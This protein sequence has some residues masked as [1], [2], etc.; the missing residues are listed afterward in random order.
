MKN[1]LL[2]S[3]RAVHDR[4]T[5]TALF[6]TFLKAKGYRLPTSAKPAFR[7]LHLQLLL[8]KGAGKHNHSIVR[9]RWGG[10]YDAYHISAWGKAFVSQLSIIK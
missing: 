5:L 7:G 10:W 6:I 4:T 1:Q 3:S 2:F 8:A 9:F